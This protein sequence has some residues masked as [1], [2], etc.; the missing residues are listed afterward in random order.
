MKKTALSF[1]IVVVFLFVGADVFA[2]SGLD[3][4][5]VKLSGSSSIYLVKDN[6]RYIFPDQK[7]YYSWY[8][9]NFSGV[10]TI[11]VE[12]LSGYKLSGL[13]TYKPGSLIKIQTNPQVYEVIN[14]AGDIKWL[15][16]EETALN[17]HGS[18]WAKKVNDVSPGFFSA[19]NVVG[20]I[21]ESMSNQSTA[22]WEVKKIMDPD[23]SS[24]SIA[25]N[26]S[27]YGV[28]WTAKINTPREEVYFANF[29]ANGNKTSSNA[30][31]TNNDSTPSS[32]VSAR[33]IK[34][35]WTGE[36]YGV[37]LNDFD[38]AYGNSLRLMI[39]DRNG[40]ILSDSL[41]INGGD[42][43]VG[44]D[45]RSLIWTGEK[46]AI[47]SHKIFSYESVWN[48]EIS[49]SRISA[50]GSEVLGTTRVNSSI[51]YSE[52]PSVAWN[53]EKY[54]IAWIE[55]ATPEANDPFGNKILFNIVDKDGVVVSSD[56][57]LV[58]AN[59]STILEW[60]YLFKSSRG[61]DLFYRARDNQNDVT[62]LSEV[63]DIYYMQIDASGNI[64]KSPVS[65]VHGSYPNGILVLSVVKGIDSFGLLYGKQN[66]VLRD[67]YFDEVD[68]NGNLLTKGER[69]INLGVNKNEDIAATNSGYSVI[70][71]KFIYGNSEIYFAHKK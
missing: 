59:A 28:I 66:G 68:F 55:Y 35:I 20:E 19:Y 6:L 5:L 16:N 49:L 9:N 17:R 38:S 31:L 61:Y 39:L 3:G 4:Q 69:I 12:K 41:N 58:T 36:K 2:A 48:K 52:S 57:T 43:D 34:I 70:W 54:G 7:T 11:T 67:L 45:P 25:W 18:N 13:I 64:L 30:R 56:K 1:F 42:M 46:W 24:P 51:P 62:S 23:S 26:G 47:V 27:G 71:Q 63:S 29:D 8:G 22:D 44:L 60:P 53:G 33:S 32:I 15:A 10:E 14:D 21:N 37:L 50:D 65:I 40:G